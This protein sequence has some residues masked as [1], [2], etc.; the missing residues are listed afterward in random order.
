MGPGFESPLGHHVAADAISFA[1]TFLQKSPLTHF[2]AAPPQTGPAA[3][4]SGLV[5][6][7]DLEACPQNCM[8]HSRRSKVRF[9]PKLFYA[10]AQKSVIR[11]LPCSSSPNRTRCTGLRFSFWYK[12]ESRGMYSVAMFHVGA[13]V[14]SLAPT[15]LQKS[16]LTHFVAAPLQTGP[17]ALV[18]DIHKTVHWLQ[19]PA[20]ADK[21]LPTF[22]FCD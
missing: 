14:I 22:L 1:A 18:N 20:S 3:L 10:H 8:V 12:P 19:K 9:A 6:G 16:P 21:S 7:A 13:S 17:A 4:G 5:S 2:V 15:F 11:P